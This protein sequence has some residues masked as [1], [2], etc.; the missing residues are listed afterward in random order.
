M[1]CCGSRRVS[2]QGGLSVR[3]AQA[4]MPARAA[5][6]AGA[7]GTPLPNERASA[8]EGRQLVFERVASGA[9]T[10]GPA[11]ANA[12]ADLAPLLV[13][14]KASGLSYRFAQVGDIL[15]VHPAD[16]R[17]MFTVPGLRWKGDAA[18]P[19]ATAALQ[20]PV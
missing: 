15:A 8:L 18:A 3:P 14:G 17:Q 9:Q 6:S 2:L 16:W 5:L 1:S 7:S 13:R 20:S 19:P 10:V 4:A 11:P 12:S